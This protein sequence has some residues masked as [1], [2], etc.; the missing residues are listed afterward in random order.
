MTY[1]QSKNLLCKNRRE[2]NEMT[3]AII[4]VAAVAVVAFIVGAIIRK[5]KR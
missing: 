2:V 3:T 4:I 1:W 5:R